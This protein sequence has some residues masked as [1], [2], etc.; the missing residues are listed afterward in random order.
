MP[1]SWAKAFLP[2]IALLNCTGNPVM[3]ETYLHARVL[4]RCD[5]V[6]KQSCVV[7]GGG[8]PTRAGQIV[9][10]GAGADRGFDRPP[11]ESRP[12]ARRLLP[13][14]IDVLTW[15]GALKRNPTR[16]TSNHHF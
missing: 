6:Q 7:E 4:D 14:P 5:H 15:V 1:L 16:L 10:P 8:I 12:P 11:Q 9:R 13:R 3:A 2:T